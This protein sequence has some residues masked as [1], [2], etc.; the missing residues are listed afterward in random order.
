VRRIRRWAAV[1]ADGK[2]LGTTGFEG[3]GAQLDVNEGDSQAFA[4]ARPAAVRT[5]SYQVEAYLPPPVVCV[6]CPVK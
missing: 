4:L 5:I 1:A 6:A 2:V 3:H